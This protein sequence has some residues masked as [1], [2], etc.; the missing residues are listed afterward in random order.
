MK[1]LLE[2]VVSREH[3]VLKAHAK[4][5]ISVAILDGP[6]RVSAKPSREQ[7]GGPSA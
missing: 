7:G 1:Y 5:D 3:E 6:R 2:D 4:V